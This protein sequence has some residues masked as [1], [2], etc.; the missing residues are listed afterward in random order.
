M[1]RLASEKDRLAVVDDQ[2]GSPTW[3]V[4]LA[5]AISALLKTGHRP[6]LPVAIEGCKVAVVLLA[7]YFLFDAGLSLSKGVGI[8]LCLAGVFLIVR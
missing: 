8:G 6:G 3:T 1:L 5:A 7:S 2:I 4:D